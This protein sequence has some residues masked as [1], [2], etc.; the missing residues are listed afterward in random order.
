M[1]CTAL[2]RENPHVFIRDDTGRTR[3]QALFREQ[4]IQRKLQG[5]WLSLDAAVPDGGGGMRAGK[6]WL[7]SK[8]INKRRSN[9][10]VLQFIGL[11]SGLPGVTDSGDIH[12]WCLVEWIWSFLDSMHLR[13]ALCRRGQGEKCGHTGGTRET[14]SEI[15]LSL[16]IGKVWCLSL[17]YLASDNLGS[18]SWVWTRKHLAFVEIVISFSFSFSPH[19]VGNKK[20]LTH[21]MVRMK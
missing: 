3:D 5:G 9:F 19:C 16:F 21:E 17:S 15:V 4:E 14:F 20:D 18:N 7:H 11:E 6:S 12:F 13:W 1:I 10:W 2:G 8:P